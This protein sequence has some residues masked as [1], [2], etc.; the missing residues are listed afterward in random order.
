MHRVAVAA[1]KEYYTRTETRRRD[2]FSQTDE[3]VAMATIYIAQRLQVKAT[4]TLTQSGNTAHWLAQTDNMA[5]IYA[6]SPDRVARRKL[7]LY[8]GV[9]PFPIHHEGKNRDEILQEMEDVLLK[10]GV[11]ENGDRVILTFGEPIGNAGGTNSLK[12]VRIGQTKK[13]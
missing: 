8:R 1:E 9:F 5:L 12:I 11:V 4:V 3:S 2:A 13:Q 10:E 6:L 7:T